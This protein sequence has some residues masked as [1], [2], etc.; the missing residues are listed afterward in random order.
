MS[1]I[2]R[3]L[4]SVFLLA[5]QNSFAQQKQSLYPFLHDFCQPPSCVTEN[6]YLQ[7]Y[8]GM[9]RANWHFDFSNACYEVSDGCLTVRSCGEREAKGILYHWFTDYIFSSDSFLEYSHCFS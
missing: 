3:T 4:T 7:K 8:Y 2:Y 9:L 5:C 1:Q 6:D